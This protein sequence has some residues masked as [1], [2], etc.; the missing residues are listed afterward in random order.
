[1]K[2]GIS[3]DHNGY[4]IAQNVKDYLNKK[5]YDV[6]DYN[7][8]YNENDDYPVEAIKLCENID[9]LKFGILICGSGV[10]MSIIANK[11]RGV[12]CARVTNKEEAKETRE[13]QDANCIALSAKTQNILEVIDVFIETPFSNVERHQRRI[14]SIANYEN[15]MR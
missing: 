11:V 2:I 5:G 10:G 9:N 4:E 6:T 7:N 1:M 3:Y 14:K 12:R 15:N 8:I 13:H